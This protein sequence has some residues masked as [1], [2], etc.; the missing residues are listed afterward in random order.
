MGDAIRERVAA[1]SGDP[2]SFWIQ[3]RELADDLR[4]SGAM[5][6]VEEL[7]N[8]Y[9]LGQET[10]FAAFYVLLVRHFRDYD[11]VAYRRLFEAFGRDFADED[12]LPVLRTEYLLTQGSSRL[13]DA[14]RESKR[15]VAR[16]GTDPSAQHQRAFVIAELCERSG[17]VDDALVEEGLEAVETAIREGEERH[18]IFHA[19]RARLLIARGEFRAARDE[20]QLA[21]ELEPTTSPQ[22]STRIAEYR[23]IRASVAIAEQIAEFDRRQDEALK[24]LE[25]VRGQAVQLVGLL[26]AVV[27][28]I[29]T[30]TE[31]STRFEVQDAG[32][33]IMA[34]SGSILFVFSGFWVLFGQRGP[35]REAVVLGAVGLA[36]AALSL[37]V[38]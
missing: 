27:A 34:T 9:S 22:H 32:A 31:I 11:F 25:E 20:L 19:T 5:K 29:V 1:L 33:L 13:D 12:H 10:R 35:T 6:A 18:P 38:V 36:V 24:R 15:A 16:L 23:D 28:F 26:A 4:D 2:T 30:T 14:L 3:A 8:D 37:I 7:L 21:I 17:R